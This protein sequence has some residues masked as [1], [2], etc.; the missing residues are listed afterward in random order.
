[1]IGAGAL[2][3]QLRVCRSNELWQSGAESQ[4]RTRKERVFYLIQANAVVKRT[5]LHIVTSL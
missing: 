1:M 3:Q 2:G 4:V 5:F